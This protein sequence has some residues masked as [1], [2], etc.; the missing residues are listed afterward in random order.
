M[1][2]LLT[3]NEVKRIKQSQASFRPPL[4][5]EAP[6]DRPATFL[7][8]GSGSRWTDPSFGISSLCEAVTRALQQKFVQRINVIQ[9]ELAAQGLDRQAAETGD[10]SQFFDEVPD[11]EI[12]RYSPREISESEAESEILEYLKGHAGED[13]FDV[14]IALELDPSFA[15]TVCH[16]LVVEGR[17]TFAEDA[18]SD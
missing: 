14:A 9:A 5:F 7:L 13:A 8:I 11:S 15:A 6:P 12:Q 2:Q 17:L 1:S 18:I 16:R 10:L 3:Q 4:R